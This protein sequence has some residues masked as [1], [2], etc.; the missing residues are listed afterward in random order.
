MSNISRPENEEWDVL[1]GELL[2]AFPS[3][4]DLG[5]QLRLEKV[6]RVSPEN[7]QVTEEYF[8]VV[9]LLRP[10]GQFIYRLP[11]DMELLRKMVLG[12]LGIEK[13]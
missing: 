6:V 5:D 9:F 2:F 1:N 12:Y 4:N 7:A 13:S 11:H 8:Q 10:H 3:S